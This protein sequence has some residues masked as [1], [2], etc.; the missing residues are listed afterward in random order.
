M[1]IS[2]R[3]RNSQKKL[4]R[5]QCVDGKLESFNGSGRSF[6]ICKNCLAQEKKL[7]K[8]LM[9]KCRSGEKDKFMNRL[10]EIIADDRKS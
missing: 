3:E 5:L 10:K 2:C 8:T 6:Y 4:Q 9:R 1:C 7:S